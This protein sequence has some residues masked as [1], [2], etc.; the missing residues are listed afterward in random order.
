MHI[1]I[2]FEYTSI[3]CILIHDTFD[4]LMLSLQILFPLLA[5]FC[6][7]APPLLSLFSAQNLNVIPVSFSPKLFVCSTKLTW[8]RD[9][10]I[11]L[12]QAFNNTFTWKYFHFQFWEWPITPTQRSSSMAN[13]QGKFKFERALKQNKLF[14]HYL[15]YNI[16]ISAS[17]IKIS[18]Y[19][20][21]TQFDFDERKLSV[22]EMIGTISGRYCHFHGH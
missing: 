22:P 8:G 16:E 12:W 3:Q 17:Q 11:T 7:F 6:A 19:F 5:P 14:C 1:F 9:Y 2:Y 13:L 4:K 10:Y 18:S 15:S 20:V 21:L